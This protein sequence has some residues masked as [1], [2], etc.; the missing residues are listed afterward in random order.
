[1]NFWDDLSEDIF[2]SSL[3]HSLLAILK[4]EK[5]KKE[6]KGLLVKCSNCDLS[7]F[8]T[9]VFAYSLKFTSNFG[10]LLELELVAIGSCNGEELVSVNKQQL[11]WEKMR[12][13]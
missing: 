6:K 11:H 10:I 5:K 2:D 7:S 8:Y 12:Y 13:K 9:I 1:M 4:R 3:L